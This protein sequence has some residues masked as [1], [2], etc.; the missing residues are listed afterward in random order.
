SID[1]WPSGP[2]RV[3]VYAGVDPLIGKQLMLT[4]RVPPGTSAGKEAERVRTRLLRQ[5][6]ERRSPR[7]RATV[8]QLLDRYLEVVEL[9]RST[10]RTYQGCIERHIRP[11][12]GPLPLGRV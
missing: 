7:T 5:V 1:V 9:E 4:E 6:D 12:L 2:Y 10:R 11:V 8:N 3:C